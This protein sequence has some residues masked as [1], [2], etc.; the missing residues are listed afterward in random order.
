MIFKNV[1]SIINYK[2]CPVQ[3]E[4]SKQNGIYHAYGYLFF[5]L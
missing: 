3:N 1:L 4:L 2:W 5:K